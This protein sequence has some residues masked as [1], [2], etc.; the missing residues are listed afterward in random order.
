MICNGLLGRIKL[1]E[2]IKGFVPRRGKLMHDVHC[3]RIS[4]CVVCVCKQTA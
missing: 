4:G 3:C 1:Q 2:F